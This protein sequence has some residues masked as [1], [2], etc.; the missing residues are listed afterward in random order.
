[1]FIPGPLQDQS[2]SSR[3]S[4]GGYTAISPGL[5]AAVV[6]PFFG[7]GDDREAL[8]YAARMAHHPGV[9]VGVIRFF[10][11]DASRTTLRTGGSTTA[12]SKR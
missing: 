3:R 10:Q 12:P 5:R 1:M 7:G 8:A 9:T 6:V 2:T 4:N 11:R